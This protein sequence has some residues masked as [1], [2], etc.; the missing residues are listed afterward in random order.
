MLALGAGAL[1]ERMCAWLRHGRWRPLAIALGAAAAIAAVSWLGSR[2]LAPPSVS[3]ERITWGYIRMGQ[4]DKAGA[5]A[6]NRL[7]AHPDNASLQEALG[8][9][10]I[11]QGREMEAIERYR[12]AL[13][14]RPGAHAAHYNLARLLARAGRQDEALREARAAARL[15]PQPDYLALL[16]AL[17]RVADPDGR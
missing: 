3:W 17:E 8:Y 1:L 13:A 11:A 10:A 12:A 4:L 7:R 5:L 9:I 14:V 16:A 15:S 2:H 6:S